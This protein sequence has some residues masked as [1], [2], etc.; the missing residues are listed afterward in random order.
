M[1]SSVKLT[2]LLSFCVNVKFG[3][4]HHEKNTLRVCKCRVVRGIFYGRGRWEPR[5]AEDSVVSFMS[6]T[7]H[8]ILLRKS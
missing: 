6:V 1:Y 2:L 5:D 7:L 3:V 4:L 8:Q